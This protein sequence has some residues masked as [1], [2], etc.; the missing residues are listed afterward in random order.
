MPQQ[1]SVRAS[2]TSIFWIAS[3]GAGR[4]VNGCILLFSSPP[5]PDDADLPQ[6]IADAVAARL[7][8]D[9]VLV[10]QLAVGSHVDHVLVRQAAEL[11]G[12]STSCAATQ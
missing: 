9:D 6:L 8:P 12:R 5:Y 10:A 2:S 11:L 7:L 4:T 3:T 1:W